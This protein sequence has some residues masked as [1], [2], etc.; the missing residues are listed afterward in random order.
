MKHLDL[1]NLLITG[2]DGKFP[3]ESGGQN[4]QSMQ[5]SIGVLKVWFMFNSLASIPALQL[6]PVG[7][8][9]T[10]PRWMCMISGAKS[11]LILSHCPCPFN[12]DTPGILSQKTTGQKNTPDLP[13][14][15]A[16]NLGTQGHLKKVHSWIKFP[17]RT[18]MVSTLKDRLRRVPVPLLCLQQQCIDLNLHCLELLAWDLWPC[19]S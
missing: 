12:F 18:S 1:S 17:W 19:K 16:R 14:V 10:R 5:L 4:D 2:I 8:V 3:E 15:F 13:D 7:A 6:E 9:G 11:T